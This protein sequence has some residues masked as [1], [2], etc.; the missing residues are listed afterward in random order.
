VHT[1]V[2]DREAVFTGRLSW[3]QSKPHKSAALL[4]FS[5][6]SL[7]L[8]CHQILKMSRTL[9]IALSESK[10]IY[11]DLTATKK[12]SGSSSKGWNSPTMD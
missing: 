1:A 10:R 6:I 4:M 2:G 9:A 5:L 7:A 8:P 3:I 11:F 12:V